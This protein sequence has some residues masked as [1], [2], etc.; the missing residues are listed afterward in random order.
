MTFR[1]FAPPNGLAVQL[2]ATGLRDPT[3]APEFQ[4]QTLPKV[5]WNALWLVSC[6]R[7]LGRVQRVAAWLSFFQKAA[8]NPLAVQGLLTEEVA[9]RGCLRRVCPSWHQSKCARPANDE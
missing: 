3:E 5:D 1:F 7:L 2:R 9:R 8:S 4:C 6:N